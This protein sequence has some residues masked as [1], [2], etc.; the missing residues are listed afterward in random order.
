MAIVTYQPAD[1]SATVLKKIQSST[2]ESVQ[3]YGDTS[4]QVVTCYGNSSTSTP[5]SAPTSAPTS[6]PSLSTVAPSN[7]PSTTAATS[8]CPPPAATCKF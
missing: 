5:T 3:V 4:S 7:K 6:H 2:N 1:D 8:A